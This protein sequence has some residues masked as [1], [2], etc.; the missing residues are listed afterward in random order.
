MDVAWNR[1]RR[2]TI[3]RVTS[4][5]AVL[6]IDAVDPERLAAFWC[7]VLG[8]EVVESDHSGVSIAGAHGPQIDLLR[9]P[10]AKTIKN[11]LHL[12]LRADGGDTATEL[13]RLEAL[14]ARRADVGQEP[15]VS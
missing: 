6:A 5:I 1:L 9:V 12:D 8:Y 15:D 2:A 13:A 10:E 11:R 3:R 7:G 14:G 4:R